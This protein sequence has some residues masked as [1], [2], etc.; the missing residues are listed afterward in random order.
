M[1]IGLTIWGLTSLRGSGYL[2]LVA[3]WIFIDLLRLLPRVPRRWRAGIGRHRAV[4]DRAMSE[5]DEWN[6]KII[7]EFRASAGKV[8]GPFEGVPILLLH[9]RGA[10]SGTQRVSPLAYRRDGANLVVFA[11]K[12]GAPTNPDWLHNLR[13]SPEARVEVGA[14]TV[15]VRARIASGTERER[16]WSK[17]KEEYPAFASY[18]EKTERQIPVVVLEPTD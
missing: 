13:A 15:A 3:F 1:I 2:L 4:L 7:D 11:S 16:L 18:E 5:R 9:H 17:Q 8:G 14:D 6:R 10:K 12:G